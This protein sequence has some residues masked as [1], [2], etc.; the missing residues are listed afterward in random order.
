METS[1]SNSEQQKFVRTLQSFKE[2]RQNPVVLEELLSDAAVLI[3]QNKLESLYQ[4]AGDY[5]KAGIFEGGPWEEPRKLQPPLVGG[6]FKIDG[7]YS[8]FEVLSELRMLAIAKKDYTHPD[9]SR[10]QARTFLN[11]VMAL[12]LQLIF[13]AETEEARINQGEEQKRGILLFQFLAEKMSLGS[14]SATFVDEI[15][16]LTAQRPIMVKRIKEMIGYAEN[17]LSSE[18][19][20]VE[21]RE[22]IQR[23]LD[24]VH[25][26]TELSKKYPNF[27][28]YHNQFNA[29]SEMEKELEAERFADVMRDT[30]LVSPVHAN[31]ARTLAEEDAS[32]LLVLTLGLTEKGEANLNEHFSLVK[33]LVSLAIYPV[34]AQSLYGLARML[35]RGV[36]SSP[37][38]IPGLE[39]IVEI[40]MLPEVEKDLLAS[41]DNPE[42]ITPVGI[43]LSGLLSVLGQP[44][45]IGQGMNPTCQSARGISLWSQHD[46]GFLLELIAR[47]CRD[48][49]IDISF[50]GAEIN[51][52]LIAGGLA[53]DLHKELDAVSLILVPHLDRVYD[54]MMKRSALRGEDGHKFVNPEFYGQWISKEFS[55][56]INP[57]TGAVTNYEQ[58]A[59]LFYA[60]HHP[61][62]NE[63]HQ[64]IYPNPVGIF[65]TTANADLLGLHAISIQRI[66]ADP[67][68]ETRVY[69]YNPNNDSGQDWGQGIKSTVRN[70]GEEEGEAS[71]PFDQFLSR[72]YAYH[73]NPNEMGA[74]ETVPQEII[75]RVTTLAKESWG[76]KY[77][78]TDLANP[79]LI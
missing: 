16:R 33:E 38:V 11:K 66:D 8:I 32:H 64:L 65:V 3:D 9:V 40:E 79:F 2:N 75:D 61:D 30:G 76:Q 56:V 72:V 46:P 74:V 39:R 68:G 24:S 53:P 22:S 6:S 14:L 10:E 20:S 42:D 7:N 23:Y 21:G 55:S 37:P 71:L 62:Y 52:S 1:F 43:L 41:R 35:E 15:D 49:E 70:H 28:D 26:P 77:Q 17:L 45:G 58:F 57:V 34:T 51:S 67:S 63:G 12:N 27:A 59:R 69:F 31:L 36:L 50:E 25:A 13:P 60:T 44:L 78:W 18:D 19:L 73:Y 47:A 29:L 54:E 5:D 48:G 4:L